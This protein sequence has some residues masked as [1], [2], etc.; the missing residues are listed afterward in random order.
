[1]MASLLFLLQ[2][3]YYQTSLD[4]ESDKTGKPVLHTQEPGE[5][6][7]EQQPFYNPERQPLTDEK[8]KQFPGFTQMNDEALANELQ[9]ITEMAEV[10]KIWMALAESNYI[11]NQIVV[12]LESENAADSM[13]QMGKAEQRAV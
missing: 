6:N 2:Y 5:I 8:L 4:M 12:Y 13:V 3:N 11:E 7:L 10:F 9:K 1:M